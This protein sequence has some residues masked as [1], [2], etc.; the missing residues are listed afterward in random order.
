MK[1][2]FIAISI[3]A[4][5][6]LGLGSITTSAQI[7]PAAKKVVRVSKK[8]TKGTIHYTKKGAV[9]SYKGGRWVTVRTYRGGKWVTKKV[10]RGT[11]YVVVGNKKNKK[12]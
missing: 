1:K 6:F 2:G 9:K 5:L 11:K 4:L 8:A 12:P 3:M 10:W 7:V